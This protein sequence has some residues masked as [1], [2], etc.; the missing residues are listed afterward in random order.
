MKLDKTDLLFLS[1][2]KSINQSIHIYEGSLQSTVSNSGNLFAFARFSEEFPKEFCILNLDHF[3]SVY[4]LVSSTGETTLEFPED[5]EYLIIK[6]NKTRQ[7]IK[8]CDSKSVEELDKSKNYAIENP[9]ISFTLSEDL[10]EYGKKSA[11]I[12]GFKNLVFEG[13]EDEIYMISE[14]VL[15]TKDDSAEKH[16][17]KIEQQNTTRKKFSAI[18][19]VSMLKM[20]TDDYNVKIDARGGA[21]FTSKSKDY[22]FFVTLQ[23]P[24]IFS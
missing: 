7:D 12:N 6:S 24:V 23:Q 22:K 17:T 4:S 15:F 13:D 20:L 21:Q 11:A 5:G 18:F 9:D 1:N 3:I 2:F 19:D 16:R 14:T 8:F 10:L